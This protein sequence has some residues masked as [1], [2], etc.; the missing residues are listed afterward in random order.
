MDI[1]T[2]T[3]EE[4]EYVEMANMIVEGITV[5]DDSGTEMKT[6]AAAAVITTATMQERSD[7][8]GILYR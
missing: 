8:P 5:E 2:E 7:K 4:Q 3:S 6:A 1:W